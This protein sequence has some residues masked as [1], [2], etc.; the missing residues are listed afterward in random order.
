MFVFYRVVASVT[1][2]AGATTREVGAGAVDSGTAV[3]APPAAT[4]DR[5][6]RDLVSIQITYSS[7][8]VKELSRS[9]CSK[10][11]TF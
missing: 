11:A 3:D 10:E 5:I 6:E 1:S 7:I 4:F 9:A 2:D 8:S